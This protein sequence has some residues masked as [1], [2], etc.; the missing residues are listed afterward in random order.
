MG[1]PKSLHEASQSIRVTLNGK[2]TQQSP[3]GCT[4]AGPCG[5][6]GSSV[7]IPSLTR[8]DTCL[9]AQSCCCSWPLCHKREDVQGNIWEIF[10]LFVCFACLFGSSDL[11]FNA[12]ALL[13]H[14]GATRERVGAAGALCWARGLQEGFG[15]SSVGCVQPPG[16]LVLGPGNAPCCGLAPTS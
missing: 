11:G 5:D 2:G 16:V 9:G 13:Q 10:A 8:G 6:K 4:A 3:G 15:G 14:R 7:H 12:S 1:A